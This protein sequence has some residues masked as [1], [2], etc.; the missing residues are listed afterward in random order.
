[1]KQN[2]LKLYFPICL[3]DD[4]L[5][6]PSSIYVSIKAIKC[7]SD[8]NQCFF[9]GEN[10]NTTLSGSCFVD[11]MVVCLHFYSQTIDIKRLFVHMSGNKQSILYM[12][13]TW[14]CQ[15]AWS[16]VLFTLIHSPLS[17]EAQIGPLRN[18]EPLL[19]LALSSLVIIQM[20]ND[21]EYGL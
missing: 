2:Q 7:A 9:L 20:V 10:I 21:I 6:M 19:S 15:A 18:I 14:P 12:K 1:M 8:S 11:K 13:M 3:V 5:D 4:G 16:C 17:I